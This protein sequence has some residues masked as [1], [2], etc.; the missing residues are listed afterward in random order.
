MKILINSINYLP[1]LTGI[2]KYSGEMSEWLA[3]QGHEVRVVTAPPYYPAWEV[4]PG[5]SGARYQHEK[6]EGVSVY[7]C[8]LWVPASPTGLTRIIHLATFGLT[9]LPLMLWHGLVWRPDVV[10][11]I[12]PPLFS[13]PGAW[14]AGRLGGAKTWLHIQDYEVDAAFDLDIIKSECLRKF[15][16]SVERWMMARFDRVS[17]ISESMIKKLAEKEIPKGKQFLFA[18]WVDVQHI[19]P[20]ERESDFRMQLNI[21]AGAKVLLYSGNMGKKQGLE[22]II[23]AAKK[24]KDHS[25]IYFVLCGDGA[26]KDM[27]VESSIDL[28]NVLF[29]PLQPLEKLNEL[30]SLADIHLLPQKEGAE[31]LV[32]PS[33][34][35]NMAASGRPVIATAR[36]GTEV[37]L[38]VR[39]CGISVPPEDLE[40]FVEAVLELAA[41]PSRRQ[42][43]GKA[44]RVFAHEAWEKGKI[45]SSAFGED[46]Q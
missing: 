24:L 35:T 19:A 14:V 40:S 18:N 34:L 7:R 37:E 26:V 13:A 2:G 33:K 38:V 42:E 11:T 41:N 32:M 20:L 27:L 3:A 5:Y 28:E 31:D 44:G 39:H 43:L 9:S 22:L 25:D 8:P 23:N 15:V 30:L 6:I 1:E 4:S 21:P 17:T 10:M 12:E 46:F 29:I 16:L 45:L 36:E